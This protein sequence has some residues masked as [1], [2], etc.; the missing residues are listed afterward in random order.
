[1]AN[2]DIGQLPANAEVVQGYNLVKE[3]FPGRDQTSIAVVAEFSSSPLT[4]DR[5]GALYDLSRRYARMPGVVGV[6]SIVDLDPALGRA[7]YQR[8]YTGPAGALPPQVTEAVRAGVG[9]N[10]AVVNVLTNQAAESDGAREIVRA[11]RRD[12]AVADGRIEV[13]GQ[14]AFDLDI[15]NFIVERTP[16]AVAFIVGVTV[17]VLFLMLGSMLLPLKAVVM[18]FL[19]LSAS[20]GALVWI[21]QD[22]HFS[23]VL[24]FQPSSIDPSLPVLLFCIVFGLSMDYEVL[25]MSRMKEEWE[26][27]H[28]NR[29]AVAE[30]LELSGRLV[31][32]AAAIMVVVFLGFALAEVLLI[33]SIGLGM[34]IA[35]AIDA[36]LV[37]A[38]I[39]PATMRLLGDLNWWAPPALVR[40]H[41]RIG[42]GEPAPRETPLVEGSRAS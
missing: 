25:L 9:R 36:T 12:R 1:M 29:H 32:G 11:I 7:D 38:L 10:V 8:M 42:L 31:T 2:G 21:F 23:N 3:K 19:S 37:R 41:R 39:V 14:T 4:A 18:N 27:S 16:V 15:V 22:G 33:K 30:G 20:F 24:K 26:R 17:I 40:L 35:V 13:T 5:V 28:D 34:A 6:N